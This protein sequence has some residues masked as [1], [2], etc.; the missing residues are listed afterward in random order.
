M[1]TLR[2]F[3]TDDALILHRFA[4]PNMPIDKIEEMIVEWNEKRVNNKYFEMFAILNDEIIVGMISLYQHS[5]EVISIGPEIFSDHR[6]KGYGKEALSLAIGI[7]K[8][9]GYKIVSQQ[10]RTNNAASIALHTSL[11]FETSDRVYTNEKGNQVFIY[12]KS[13]I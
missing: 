10:I 11:G 9:K 6:R 13:I 8:V 5:K 2:N 7:A 1:L 4:Y 3:S 12:L